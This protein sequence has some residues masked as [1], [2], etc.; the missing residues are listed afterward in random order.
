MKTKRKTALY[1]LMVA[2][3]FIFSYVESLLP[4]VGIPGIKL[5]LANLV[6]LVALYLLRPRD[7]LAISCLRI[8]LVGLTFG[9]PSS[10]L[11]SFAGGLTS[12]GVM[13]VCRRT[14]KFSLLGVSI[15][16]GVSHNFAQLVI[17]ALVLRTPR[18]AWYLPI[19]LLSGLLTGA[20]IGIVTRLCLPK[21]RRFT[22]ETP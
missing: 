18:I 16:G 4:V 8:L 11:Y 9:S 3:A 2:L 12:F 1:G 20:L 5:G 17:A 6:V 7:A 21:L 22:R 14:G 10:M 19:L 15:V 13:A